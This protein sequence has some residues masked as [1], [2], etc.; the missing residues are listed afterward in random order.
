[1]LLAGILLCAVLLAVFLASRTGAWRQR[2]APAP[3][4]PS[5][6]DYATWARTQA[7]DVAAYSAF[8]RRQGV[9]AIVPMPELLRLGRRWRNCGGTAFV[10]PP[11]ERWP[12]IVPTLRLFDAL[13]KDGLL[14]GARVASAYRPAAYNRCEGGSDG[15][16]HLRNQALDLDLGPGAPDRVARLCAHW[17]RIGPARDWGLGFYTPTRIHLDATG[18]RTWGSN[19]RRGTSLCHA[20]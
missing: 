3:A 16:R 13:R 20:R 6:D 5:A 18:F 15:S 10:V 7:A 9:D 2:I 12:A 4:A 17:R 8:L 19:H 14:D 1:L 11:R